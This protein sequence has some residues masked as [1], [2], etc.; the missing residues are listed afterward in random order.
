MELALN[1]AFKMS[2]APNPSDWRERGI[3]QTLFLGLQ[4]LVSNVE[5]FAPSRASTLQRKLVEFRRS[6]DPG[7]RFWQ[8]NQD[9]LQTG[10]VEDILNLAAK[11]TPD[12]R[13]Q[14]Y[15]HAAWKA[16]SQGESERARQIISDGV[17]NPISRRQMLDEIERQAAHKAASE[18]KLDQ[19]RQMLSRLRTN[20][21]RATALTNLAGV[22]SSKGDKET[23]IRLLEEA[24]LLVGNKAANWTQIQAQL[25]LARAFG[26]LDAAKSLEILETMI[27]QLNGLLDAA[28]TL[29]GFEHQYYKDGELLW[30]GS[31][32]SNQISQLID[33]LGRLATVDFDRAKDL[34]Q[35][36]QRPEVRLMA[37]LSV[38]RAVLSE[39]AQAN[40]QVYGRRTMISLM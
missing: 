4:R 32:L 2:T 5:K 27:A 9:V 13:D 15:Q 34:A 19:A 18:G 40:Q 12:L 1:A 23:A 28:E 38:A 25:Q 33:E 17:T 10:T 21:D 3:A 30:Q 14:V 8:D 31:N 29:D 20:E 35:R 22:L 26:S 39:R 37:Q 11:A 6:V 24:R 16:S 7:T 36:F